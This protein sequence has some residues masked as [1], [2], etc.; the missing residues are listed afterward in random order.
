MSNKDMSLCQ[1][2]EASV[3]VISPEMVEIAN[4]IRESLAT[5]IVEG[6][7][8]SSGFVDETLLETENPAST[9]RINIY[10]AP[11]RVGLSRQK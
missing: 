8:R 11:R 3:V 7:H 1:P 4:N 2:L 9:I 10:S 6:F 5:H